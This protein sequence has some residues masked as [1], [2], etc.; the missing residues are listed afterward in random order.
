MMGFREWVVHNA[1]QKKA[2]ESKAIP[3]CNDSE[4]LSAKK[5]VK[6][7]LERRSADH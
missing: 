5:I 4:K 6:R 2:A 7:V 3:D 1:K